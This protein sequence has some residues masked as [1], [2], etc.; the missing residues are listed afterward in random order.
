MLLTF[1]KS[2]VDGLISAY[3]LN[4]KDVHNKCTLTELDQEALAINAN[5][6][7]PKLHTIRQDPKGRWKSGVAIDMWA[8]S[9]RNPSTS[10]FKIGTGIC[11]GVQ[12]IKITHHDRKKL[13]KLTVYQQNLIYAQSWC[14][15]DLSKWIT[16][17]VDG[18]FLAKSQ[19]KEL[20]VNDG[21]AD[22]ESFFAFKMFQSDFEGKIIHWTAL[23]YP[24]R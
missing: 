21:F 7:A 14:N 22:E 2:L 8:G 15:E 13:R 10:P 24:K 6:K 4:S 17:E 18:Q 9:P 20:A 19:I 3:H 5:K 12:P 16:V 11:H 1:H 23:R